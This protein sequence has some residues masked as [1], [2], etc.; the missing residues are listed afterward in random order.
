MQVNYLYK[1]AGW[2]DEHWGLIVILRDLL[3]IYKKFAYNKEATAL[4]FI[5]YL[6][7]MVKLTHRILG[8][9]IHQRK[10]F[11]CYRNHQFVAKTLDI[12]A[13]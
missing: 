12:V 5:R 1:E 4:S 11:S 10:P 8:K 7:K 3:T 9:V 6:Q 2:T 13:Q